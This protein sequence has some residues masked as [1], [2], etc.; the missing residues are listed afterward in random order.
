M[1]GAA[2]AIGLGLQAVSLFGSS[3]GTQYTPDPKSKYLADLEAIKQAR[4]QA[5]QQE[6]LLRQQTAVSNQLAQ[7]QQA[8]ALQQLEMER[9][10]YSQTLQTQYQQSIYQN[11]ANQLS[12]QV[13][14]FGQQANN[15]LQ[16]FGVQEQFG[17]G[18]R[19]LDLANA[20][21]GM[22]Y[23]LGQ[24]QRGQEG[25][26]AQAQQALYDQNN[27]LSMQRLGLQDVQTGMKG[28]ALDAQLQGIGLNE[29][30]FAQQQAAQGR[31]LQNQATSANLQEGQALSA[32]ELQRQQA[33]NQLLG[34]FLGNQD[35][36]NQQ[37]SRLQALGLAP[38]V[39]GAQLESDMNLDPRIMAARQAQQAA[40]GNQ[41]GSAQMAN[42]LTQRQIG[43]E[44]DALR[45]AGLLQQEGFRQAREGVER[46]RGGLA[47]ETSLT[48]LAR[49]GTQLESAGQQYQTNSFMNQLALAEAT[50]YL[51]RRLLP[52]LTTKEGKRNLDIQRRLSEGGI[53]IADYVREYQNK[54]NQNQMDTEAEALITNLTSGLDVLDSDI[55]RQRQ[56]VKD[57]TKST[58]T[59]NE[60]ALAA[61]LA[62]LASG[63]YG[64][65]SS[66]GGGLSQG[67]P[68][69]GG[70]GF[71]WGG[72]ASL[73]QGVA[74]SGLLSRNS[75]PQQNATTFQYNYQP[76]NR[77]PAPRSGTFVDNS[78][79]N[80]VN[81]Y[82]SGGF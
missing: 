16:R 65:L 2:P 3:G 55:K 72:L 67:V 38:G 47:V 10:Y 1:G 62:Q 58:T 6:A 70:G 73:V 20:T 33:M 29:Q 81:N 15:Q 61:A 63:Q 12:N 43:V 37:M 7:Y 59:S 13:G 50:D 71:D 32:A 49:R 5:S 45:N 30:Q 8:Q 21:A 4:I 23:G 60:L 31:G 26:N 44:Q 9:Q 56:A 48:D 76:P 19:Q 39:Q 75:T 22:E 35:Q 52:D 46:E 64:L 57:Q 14:N 11:Q 17:Q 82:P 53:D 42:Q 28:T 25:M 27:A 40:Y 18:N 69:G 24:V 79:Q 54:L 78:L 77:F 74:Q 80:R 66:I 41:V 36:A 68:S 51:Q 34:V